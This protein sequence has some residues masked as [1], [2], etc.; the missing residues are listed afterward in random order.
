[1][2]ASRDFVATQVASIQASD[3]NFTEQQ[4]LDRAQVAFSRLSPV[5]MGI[6]MAVALLV[7]DALGPQGVAPFIYFAF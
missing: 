4:F 6:A 5:Q 7:I 1:V 3:P 2:T